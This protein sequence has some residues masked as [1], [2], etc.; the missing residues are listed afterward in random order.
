VVLLQAPGGLLGLRTL[1]K[2]HRLH[3]NQHQQTP[4]RQELEQLIKVRT[5]GRV[6]DLRVE[7]GLGQ[8]VLRGVACSYHVKQLAQHGVL[9]RFPGVQLE[10]A[11][12]V[13]RAPSLL[14]G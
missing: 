1:V 13:A 12:S 9:D 2:E 4:S 10:N 5:G 8:V 6:Q 3:S 7:V 11:I 14:A